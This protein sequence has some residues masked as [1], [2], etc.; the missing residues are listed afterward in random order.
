MLFGLAHK[1]RIVDVRQYM[2]SF[3][4]CTRLLCSRP[5][6]SVSSCRQ[7]QDETLLQHTDTE[8]FLISARNSCM[9]FAI[10]HTVNDR[11]LKCSHKAPK[12]EHHQNRNALTLHAYITCLSYSIYSCS[13]LSH[14]P[15]CHTHLQSSSTHSGCNFACCWSSMRPTQFWWKCILAKKRGR[16]IPVRIARFDSQAD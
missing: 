16:C 5:L 10:S 9:G 2:Y 1:C 4:K 15:H 3:H 8:S 6:M 14:P 7:W 12:R 13:P 11:Q